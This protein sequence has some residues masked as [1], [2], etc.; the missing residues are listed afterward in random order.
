MRTDMLRAA[1][2]VRRMLGLAFAATVRMDEDVDGRTP[3]E[4]GDPHAY[5]RVPTHP[6][7]PLQSGGVALLEPEDDYFDRRV[8]APWRR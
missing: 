1:A 7:R 6:R 8:D 3:C 4:P 5:A 2:E